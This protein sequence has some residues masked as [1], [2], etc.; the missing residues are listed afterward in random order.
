MI[1]TKFGAKI[2]LG[3]GFINL[4]FDQ[5]KMKELGITNQD[6]AAYLRSLTAGDYYGS[7][8]KWPAYLAYRPDERVF[9]NA[10]TFE[11]VEAFVTANPSRWMANPYSGDGTAVTL[12]H[13]LQQLHA[14]GTGVGYLAYGAHV[15]EP[16]LRIEGTSYFYRDGVELTEEHETFEELPGR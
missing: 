4:W 2:S 15:D 13:D 16:P 5:A 10:Y 14:I 1:D 11:Q 12:E 9:F 7:R 6:V 8:D 3:G